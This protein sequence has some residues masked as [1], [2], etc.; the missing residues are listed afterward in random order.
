MAEVI[1]WLDTNVAWSARKVRE[2]AALAQAKGVKVVVHAQVHLES[3]R[4]TRELAAKDGKRFSAERI[5]TFLQQLD[6]EVM[7]VSFDQATAEAWAELLH[8][9][10]PT[11]K[12]WQR[13]KLLSVRASLPSEAQVSAEGIPM[14]TDWLIA[15]EAERCGAYVAVEDKG[16]E[17]EALRALSP[18]RALTYEETLAWLH[19][20]ADA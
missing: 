7:E 19:G 12:A 10:Y 2:I 1:L 5:R 20:H 9:R 3:C 16:E 17:W 6:V 11:D 14:T 13:A 8:Q 4:Q 18:K 15:L